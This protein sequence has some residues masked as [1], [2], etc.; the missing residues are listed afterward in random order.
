[1]LAGVWLIV[2]H[3]ANRRG[4]I[5]NDAAK[6]EQSKRIVRQAIEAAIRIA[7][8]FIVVIACYDI[9]KPFIVPIVWAAI[10]A[11]AVKPICD[12]LESKF[13]LSRKLAATLVTLCLLGL[14]ISPM[15][16]L[17]NSV[18]DRMISVST[19]IKSGEFDLPEPSES[20]KTWPI[21][22]DNL[23]RSWQVA[24]LNVEEFLEKNEQSIKKIGKA[25]LSKLAE[26][27]VTTLI[28]AFSII[29]AGIFLVVADSATHF[30][31][32][33]FTRLAGERGQ[34]FASL[35]NTT[36]RNVTRGILGVAVLQSFLA[37]LG[38]Y[39]IGLPAP[40]LLAGIV[41]VMSIVQVNPVLLMVPLAAYVFSYASPFVAILYMIWSIVVGIM[42][43]ILKPIIMGKGADVPM[44]IIF[45]GA[46]GGFISMGFIGLFVGAVILVVGY[47]L[48]IAWLKQDA[49][50]YV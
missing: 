43:N 27:G 45:L 28:M 20:V 33:L 24:A 44:M 40:V 13:T 14:T 8:L 34:R 2:C 41:L 5:M 42:D 38:F 6:N 19:Q 32:K 9:L 35:S 23:Y 31:N 39:V 22:G 7:V 29:V 3:H 16:I 46:V 47:E 37:W 15:V 4:T 49:S 1:M 18:A 25:I 26:L 48:F 30:S 36:V 21:V 17:A 50:D 12:W 10:I 11:I